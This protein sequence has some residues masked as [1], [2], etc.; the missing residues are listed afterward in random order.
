L[1]IIRLTFFACNKF[2]VSICFLLCLCQLLPSFQN[3][4]MSEYL[5]LK[6]SKQ[7]K[8]EETE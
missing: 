1:A 8:G 3:R 7:R 5:D 4:V 2:F 6:E